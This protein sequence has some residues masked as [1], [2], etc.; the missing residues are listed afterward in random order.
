MGLQE[1]GVVREARVV[2]NRR[3]VSRAGAVGERGHRT[4][5]EVVPVAVRRI[6]RVVLDETIEA[7]LRVVQLLEVVLLVL[8]VEQAGRPHELRARVVRGEADFL[9]EVALVVVYRGRHAEVLRAG[10]QVE[11]AAVQQRLRAAEEGLVEAEVVQRAVVP[12]RVVAVVVRGVR[13]EL[14]G[15][16]ITLDLQ[17]RQ[18]ELVRCVALG[19]V[20]VDVPVVAGIRVDR[21][22]VFDVVPV[23]VL[24]V[25]ARRDSPVLRWRPDGSQADELR[26]VVVAV[27]FEQRLVYRV[28]AVD[29]AAVTAVPDAGAHAELAV[30][31]RCAASDTGLIARRAT[32]GVRDLGTRI[33]ARLGQAWLV[34]DEPDGA[35]LGAGAEQRALRTTQDLDT[36]DVEGLG[37]CLVRVKGQ[38]AHLD[39]R[40]VDV[41]TGRTCATGGGYAAD[42]DVVG[43]GVVDV[44]TRRELGD[45]LEVLDA[46]Q[47]EAFLVQRRHAQRHLA[48]RLFVTGRGDDDLAELRTGVF[49]RRRGLCERS[50]GDG[51]GEDE[52]DQAAERAAH[53][54]H[55]IDASG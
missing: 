29:P 15:A 39:G 52:T 3:V 36:I 43:A 10:R 27:L 4:V 35:T 16:Q 8:R 46:A 40:V 44:D 42:R 20:G 53:T 28:D 54:G 7:R 26:R 37:Q 32:L 13:N 31:D 17:C 11:T 55:R 33:A 41:D 38:R 22:V 5:A 45:V 48:Q 50:T 14:Y 12:G 25:D 24:V 30:D 18:V 47:V 21:P 6:A 2:G 23:A 34:G 1:V 49:G 9:R 51:G 19:R